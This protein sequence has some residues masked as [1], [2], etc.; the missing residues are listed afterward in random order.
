MA[1]RHGRSLVCS[2]LL[3]ASLWRKGMGRAERLMDPSGI[4]HSEDIRIRPNA[5]E[6]QPKRLS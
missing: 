5:D 4:M 1:A 2:A 6:M 3:R